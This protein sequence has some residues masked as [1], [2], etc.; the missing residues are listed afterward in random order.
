MK[1]QLRWRFSP[2][3]LHLSLRLGCFIVLERAY[4]FGVCIWYGTFM[5]SHFFVA[6]GV[7]VSGNGFY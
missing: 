4:A 5:M 7:V 3:A 2:F 1:R 6:E